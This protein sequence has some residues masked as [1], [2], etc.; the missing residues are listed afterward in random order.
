MNNFITTAD[1]AIWIALI[2]GRVVL[3][4]VI[5][6]KHLFRKLPW[7]SLY[8]LASTIETIVLFVI[9]SLCSYTAYYYVFYV[10]SHIV[11]LFAFSTLIEAGR[12]V[13]PGLDLPKKE[14]ALTFLM[15]TIGVIVAFVTLWPLRFIENRIELAAQLVVG[16]TFIF[17]AT[18]SRYL[19]LYWSRLV[20][21]ISATLGLLYLIQGAV[22][23]MA[24]H[25]PSAMTFEIRL[26]SEIANVLAVIAWIVVVLSPW[27]TRE[28]TEQDVL[29][30]EAAFARIEASMG[31]GEV[32]TV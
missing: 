9:A 25:H 21:G 22:R 17:I 23:A 28:Y 16:T 31:T 30:L 14:Q 24:W 5:L 26:L 19:G 27:G 3:C 18:Y 7:F 15:L 11:S 4:L 32:K 29:K 1:L 20:A 13:L 8:A 6:K 12:R 10:T 2:V